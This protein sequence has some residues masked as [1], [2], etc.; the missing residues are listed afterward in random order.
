MTSVLLVGGRIRTMVPRAPWADAVLVRDGRIAYVGDVAG[1]Q[2]LTT[3]ATEVVDLRGGTLLPGFID[4]HDHLCGTGAMTKVGADLSGVTD[5]REA[6]RRVGDHALAHPDAP[7]VRGHGFVVPVFGPSGPRRELLDEVVPDRPVVINSYDAHDVWFNTAAMRAVGLDASV[8]DPDPGSQYFVRDPDGTPTGHGV[9]GLTVLILMA[10]LG[11][12]SV[13]ALRDAQALTLDP[14]PSWGITTAFEAGIIIGANDAAEPAYLDLVERDRRGEL[15]I[16]IVGTVWTREASDDP[17]EVVATLR[18][19]NA[20]I[21]S[22]NVSVT[23]L[24]MWSDGTAMSGGALLLEPF[25][26]HDSVGSMTFPREAIEAQVAAAHLAGF[27]MHIHVDADGSTRTVLDAIEAVQRRHGRGDRRHTICHVSFLH[28]DDLPRFA[29]LG[30]IA[31]VTP[32]WGTDY[33]GVHVDLYDE[34]LG[35][36]RARTRAY[37]YGDLM[38]S[39]ATVTYGADIPGVRIDEIAP[40][41][42]IQAAVTRRRPGYPDDRPFV[43][44]QRVGLDDALRAVTVNAAYQLRLEDEIGTIEVGKRADLVALG[45]NL[46]ALPD[47]ELHQAPVVLTMLGGRITHDAR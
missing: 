25:C 42:Q 18:D 34:I 30:V 15:P 17:H 19:W 36:H 3:S 21:R 11:L 23:T 10:G 45:E 44:E 13:D 46:F 24:K 29:D 7:V 8:P 27:D 2:E 22:E 4:A 20:R 16:R 14:A 1:A 28:P 37:A 12:A 43:P 35:E 40:L 9:E 47:D 31:N 32:M 6:A 5:P 39:G 26:G 41:K 38:R 33:D